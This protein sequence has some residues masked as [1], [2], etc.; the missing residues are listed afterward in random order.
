MNKLVNQ[1]RIYRYFKTTTLVQRITP[2]PEERV[3]PS[4]QLKH[5]GIDFLGPLYIKNEFQEAERS[6][7]CLFTWS[8]TR[9]VHLELTRIMTTERF[10]LA[11]T[12]KMSRR[13]KIDVI[14]SDNFKSF[15]NADKGLRQCWE[16]IW[17]NVTQEGV[18]GSGICWKLIC[19]HAPHWGILWEI[20]EVSEDTLEK[21]RTTLS[22]FE[23]QVNCRPLTYCSDDTSDPLPLTPAAI[24]I[25]RPFQSVPLK[26]EDVEGSSSRKNP[27][28]VWRNR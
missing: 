4:P 10:V 19:P 22:V 24:I 18:Q 17:S 9:W 21:M 3:T 7:V 25:G 23:A 2:L 15:K 26:S 5:V 12:R 20:G 13:G 1:C 6:S 27:L 11:L 16:V 8:A 14:W 28:Q